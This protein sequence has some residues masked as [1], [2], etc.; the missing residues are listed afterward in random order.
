MTLQRVT[1][2]TA[3][4]A[5]P[6]LQEARRLDDEARAHKHEIARRRRLLQEVRTRQA[7]VERRCAELGVTVTY[8]PNPGAG[9]SP[10]P[11]H[12]S[13]TSRR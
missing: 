12:H 7:E 1:I 3:M 13:S 10:W 6:L 2:G 4:V 9:T 8:Q 5:T 11:N